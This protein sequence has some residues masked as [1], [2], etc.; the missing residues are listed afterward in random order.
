MTD[1]NDRSL[2]L[3]GT[4]IHSEV[5]VGISVGLA[6]LGPGDTADLLTQRADAAMLEVKA[7]RYLA[8]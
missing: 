2:S 8:R 1:R 6:P 7:V 5:G 3:I 4:S